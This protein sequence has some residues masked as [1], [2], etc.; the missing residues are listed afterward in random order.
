MAGVIT[1]NTVKLIEI[2]K[3]GNINIPIFL[4]NN[5]KK[6]NISLAGVIILSYIIDKEK[7]FDYKKISKVLNIEEKEVL[8]HINELQEKDVLTIFVEKNSQGK[9]EEYLSVE[10]LYNKLSLLM[11]G[12]DDNNTEE[13]N[14][15]V[16]FEKEFGRTLSPMEYEIIT[17]W[18]DA[19]YSDEI[20]IEA[21]R[22]A[23]YSG[24]SNLR[25]IDKIL[26][27]WNKKGLKRVDDVRRDKEKFIKSKKD[28]IEIPDYNWLEENE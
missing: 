6:L 13:N 15:Y 11:I 5:Y 1:M 28:K 23:V 25:Y 7:L 21:L 3:M 8:Q 17:S 24:A 4:L 12:E 14:I 9:M 22:E 27:E 2:M 10:P 18:L 26:F 16:M 20:I 19:K